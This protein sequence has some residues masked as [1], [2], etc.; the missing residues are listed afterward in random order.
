MVGP[1]RRCVTVNERGFCFARM[2]LSFSLPRK[3]DGSLPN[4]TFGHL[5][6]ESDLTLTRG[7]MWGCNLAGRHLILEHGSM[8]LIRER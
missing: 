8:I 1:C 7:L 2:C 3:A 6:A 4:I 5:V